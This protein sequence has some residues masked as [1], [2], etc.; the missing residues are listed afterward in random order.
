MSESR[1][2]TCTMHDVY[3]ICC[4]VANRMAGDT[5][6]LPSGEPVMQALVAASRP[7]LSAPLLRIAL[8]LQFLTLCLLLSIPC[9]YLDPN[10]KTVNV[11]SREVLLNAG[12]VHWCALLPLSL[13]LLCRWWCCCGCG[14][15]LLRAAAGGMLLLVGW[16][17]MFS[18]RGPFGLDCS[19]RACCEKQ[20][21]HLTRPSPFLLPACHARSITQQQ[22]AEW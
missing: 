6:C 11:E 1:R 19:R 18:R 2:Y 14:L 4:V 12:N 9:R 5:H 7:S 17:Q 22:P 15:L 20:G 13:L 3:C 16:L 21:C 8:P 10:T